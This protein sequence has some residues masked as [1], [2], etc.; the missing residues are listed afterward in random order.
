[1]INKSFT[2]QELEQLLADPTAWQLVRN[3]NL[4]LWES[5]ER[6]A[7]ALGLILQLRQCGSPKKERRAAAWTDREFH[8]F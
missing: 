1:M 6:R 5:L 7:L 8:G 4:V 3:T 2:D